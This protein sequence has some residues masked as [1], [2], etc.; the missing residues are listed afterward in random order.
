MV[1]SRSSEC[2]F[3]S[4]SI[5]SPFSFITNSWLPS[6][7]SKLQYQDSLYLL[8]VPETSLPL[9]RLHLNKIRLSLPIHFRVIWFCCICVIKVLAGRSCTL[10]MVTILRPRCGCINAAA[11]QLFLAGGFNKPCINLWSQLL[12]CVPVSSFHVDASHP[13]H[14]HGQTAWCLILTTFL[15]AVPLYYISVVCRLFK[16]TMTQ[17]GVAIALG[18]SY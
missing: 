9:L 18:C 11:A 13:C 5:S 6:Y 1:Q 17:N 12:T 3:N 16:R 4:F 15:G 8:S 10:G 14:H 2:S 7:L